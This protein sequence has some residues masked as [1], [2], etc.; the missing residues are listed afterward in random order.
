MP[1]TDA[2][3]KADAKVSSKAGIK[4][5]S[6]VTPS[7]DQGASLKYPTDAKAARPALGGLLRANAHKDAPGQQV[8]PSI[9]DS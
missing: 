7:G 6:P 4:P 1:A 3:S 5:Q 8:V 9:H 2:R